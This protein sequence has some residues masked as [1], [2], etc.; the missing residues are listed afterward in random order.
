MDLTQPVGEARKTAFSSMKFLKLI[1]RRLSAFN[2]PQM[3]V[4]SFLTI[5][6]LGTICLS[7]RCSVE[8]ERLSL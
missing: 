6:L 1:S 4:A 7:L 2:P 5:I 3:I 8:G